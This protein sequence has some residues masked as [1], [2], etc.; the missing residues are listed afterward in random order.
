MYEP[1]TVLLARLARFRSNAGMVELFLS[2]SSRDKGPVRRLAEE[3]GRRRVNVWLDEWEID[4]GDSIT[5]KIQEGLSKADY[6]AVWLSRAAVVSG[7]VEK[8]WQSKILG[9]I[10][11]GKVA[12]LPLL[13]EDCDIPMFLAEKKYADFRVDFDMG[14]KELARVLK[15]RGARELPHRDPRHGSIRRRTEAF[16][17]DLAGAQI[18]MPL[19]GN[20]KIT[21]SLKQLPRSGKLLRLESM[22]PRLPIRSIFNHIIS[23][24]HTSDVLLPF[25]EHSFTGVELTELARVIAYHELC[26]V[27]IG[28]I[29]QY[30]T[31]NRTKRRRAKVEAQARLS[32]LPNGYPEKVV[33]EFISMYLDESE[34][35]SILKMMEHQSENG[36][37]WRVAYAFD[38]LDPIIATWRYLDH[39]RSKEGF[40]SQD[41]LARMRH[42]FEN[43]NVRKVFLDTLEVEPLVPLVDH[44]QDPIKARRYYESGEIGVSDLFQIPNSSFSQLLEGHKLEFVSDRRVQ[45]VRKGRH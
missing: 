20:L 3:L 23:V 4:V 30:T 36:P 11:S 28:D 6:V 33:N 37:V 8:E 35:E 29:P 34:R 44:L 5:A 14:L 9:E 16:L 24:A 2:H 32:R 31:L 40:K 19:L 39:F 27:V 13:G 17:D 22:E 41:Y 10:S 42:F 43:P 45:A 12:V 15:K 1:N 26:E 18:P 21:K 38:K 25:V 7:W